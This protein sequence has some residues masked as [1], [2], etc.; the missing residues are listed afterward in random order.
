MSLFSGFYPTFPNAGVT[1]TITSGSAAFTTSGAALQ[2]AGIQRGD[3]I[4]SN[5]AALI[6]A[7]ITG[8]NAG[9]L[10]RVA[11]AS[12]AGTFPLRIGM[13]SDGARLSAKTV[14]LIALLSGGNLQALAGLTGAANKLPY[15]T[16]AG[17]MATVDFTAL[18]RAI[19]ALPLGANGRFLAMTAPAEIESRAIIG[20]VAQSGG[21]PTGALMERGSNA[22]G[23]YERFA[24]GVQICWNNNFSVASMSTPA[25][26][27]F[28]SASLAW[29]YPASFAFSPV[30]YGKASTGNRGWP[31]MVGNF[32]TDSS[33]SQA[34]VAFMATVSES[35]N[36]IFKLGA[37]GR[38]Y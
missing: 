29:V 2:S 7:T 36:T 22:N 18:G 8:Q 27:L 28:R 38:W 1:V 23:L 9:T 16:S 35:N 30:V 15:F 34:Q 12:A 24:N 17:A 11:P 10:E 5:G 32:N 3:V 20:T 6:V 4:F 14:E 31:W 19:A 25:G 33:L 21:F 26:S 13:L 37:I